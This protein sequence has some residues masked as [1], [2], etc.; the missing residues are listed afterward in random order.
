MV[1]HFGS[2]H[3]WIRPEKPPINPKNLPFGCG[4]DPKNLPFAGRKALSGEAYS[5]LKTLLRKNDLKNGGLR[6]LP[7]MSVA[8]MQRLWGRPFGVPSACRHRLPYAPSAR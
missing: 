6:W 4:Y 8:A 3:L 2:Y 5:L 1:D 7:A